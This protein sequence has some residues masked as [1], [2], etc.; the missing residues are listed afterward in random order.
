MLETVRRDFVTNVSRELKTPVTAIHAIAKTLIDDREVDEE[1]RQCFL[2]KIL[3]QS[4]RLSH[5]TSDLLVLSR[6]ESEQPDEFKPLN[7][8]E[9]VTVS[10][11]IL[12]AIAEEKGI[13]LNIQCPDD[14]VMILDNAKS[15][16]QLIDNLVDNAI[17]YTQEQDL[18]SD[19]Q[20]TKAWLPSK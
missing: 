15:L 14:K 16:A 6:L 18:L 20:A 4:Y 13:S 7:L 5:L 1:T 11:E 12:Q 17:S 2:K 3:D 8:V 10:Y 19:Y 9:T